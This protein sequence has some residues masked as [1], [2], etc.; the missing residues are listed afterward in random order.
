VSQAPEPERPTQSLGRRAMNEIVARPGL[1]CLIHALLFLAFASQAAQ[2]KA[3]MNVKDFFPRQAPSRVVYDRMSEH[4]PDDSWATVLVTTGAPSAR[5]TLIAIRD[6][7]SA[8]KDDPDVFQA[9]TVMSVKD[10]TSRAGVLTPEELI[11]NLAAPQAELDARFQRLC[12]DPRFRGSLVDVS[13]KIHAVRIELDP[14]RNDDKGWRPFKAAVLRHCESLRQALRKSSQDPTKVRVLATGLPIIR[15]EYIDMVEQDLQAVMPIASLLVLGILFAL[16]LSFVDLALPLLI[17]GVTLVWTLGTVVLLDKVLNQILQITPLIV[18]IVGISDGIHLVSRVNDSLAAAPEGSD[19]RGII[20][21]ACHEIGLACFLTSLTTIAGFLSLVAT[22]IET[23]V[24]FGIITA[25][26]IAYAYLVT[27]TL[28][29]AL[30]GLRR[31][32]PGAARA[33]VDRWGASL[34]GLAKWSMRWRRAVI[35]GALLL[36][37]IA[38][39]ATG[40]VDRRAFVFEDL[41]ASSPLRARIDEADRVYSGIVPLSFFLEG[42]DQSLIEPD[43]LAQLRKLRELLTGQ[44]GIELAQ[45]LDLTLQRTHFVWFDEAPEADRL[46]DS[47]A[48]AAQFLLMIPRDMV[49]EHLRSRAGLVSSRT[50]DLGSLRLRILLDSIQAKLPPIR[51]ALAEQGVSL[52]LTGTT[53][54]IQ[55][56]YDSILGSLESSVGLSVAFMAALFLVLFGGPRGALIALLPNLLPL[57]FLAGSLVLFRIALKPSTVLIFSMAFGIAVDDTIHFLAR[58]RLERSR[59]LEREAAILRTARETGAAIV[60]TTL[61]LSAGFLVLLI[62]S[63]EALTNQGILLAFGL[64]AALLADLIFLPALLAATTDELGVKLA[65]GEGVAP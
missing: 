10:V 34:E 36:S 57:V 31:R 29:P 59:G 26:G 6:F 24:D 13:G 52:Y 32:E 21:A 61:V 41:K 1:V 25:I 45:G 4:F 54:L 28:L 33:A 65:S 7:E 53:P 16:F 22:N 62:S 44:D 48:L 40:W 60:T 14:E 23:I 47:R 38:L 27:I 9:Q 46:P 43:T 51:A 20:S 58:F 12:R 5:S 19:R 11:P 55:E 3:G 42:S 39:V 17:V 30:L 18:L 50:R 49:E 63:F 64:A 8:L 35:G 37:I 56:V 2:C 15:A